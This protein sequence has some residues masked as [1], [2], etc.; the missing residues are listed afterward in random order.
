MSP[1]TELSKSITPLRERKGCRL[2]R[3]GAVVRHATLSRA[4][5]HARPTTHLLPIAAVYAVG[6]PVTSAEDVAALFRATLVMVVSKTITSRNVRYCPAA[7][8]RR[9]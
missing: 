1:E 4:S 8:I 6:S 2:E 3:P 5:Q 9:T 7:L